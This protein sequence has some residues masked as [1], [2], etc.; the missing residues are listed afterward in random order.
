ML[1]RRATLYF[2]ENDELVDEEEVKEEL[3]KNKYS[4]KYHSVT[5]DFGSEDYIRGTQRITK[6]I[7]W[8]DKKSENAG[9]FVENYIKAKAQHKKHKQ[10]QED[11][12]DTSESQD[13]SLDEMSFLDNEAKAVQMNIKGSQDP[14]IMDLNPNKFEK[15]KDTLFFDFFSMYAK[16]IIDTS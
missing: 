16:N 7:F 2:N 8:S 1:P 3:K 5:V 14:V 9:I 12:S 15:P 6:D 4:K 10:L 11:C 13:S